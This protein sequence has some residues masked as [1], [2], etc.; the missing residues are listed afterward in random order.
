MSPIKRQLPVHA[1]KNQFPVR[2]GEWVGGGVETLE[3]R[4]VCVEEAESGTEAFFGHLAQVLPVD[5]DAAA[6][7]FVK[8]Q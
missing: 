2:E 1:A 8:A 3:Q 6:F 7:D 5:A 4:G